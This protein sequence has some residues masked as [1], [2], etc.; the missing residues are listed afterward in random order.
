MVTVTQGL[1]VF[2]VNVPTEVIGKTIIECGIREK[3]GCTIIGY[4]KDG[5]LEP[6]PRPDTTLE[7]GREMLMIGD[8]EARNNFFKA[9][10]AS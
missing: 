2:R 1:D 9:Y 6:N 3:T 8:W 10:N 4:H 7:Q 5:T